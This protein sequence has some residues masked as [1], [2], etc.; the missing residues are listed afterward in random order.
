M[1]SK[2]HYTRALIYIIYIVAAGVG[3]GVRVVQYKDVI[4]PV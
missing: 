4:L 2:L 3:V 1:I